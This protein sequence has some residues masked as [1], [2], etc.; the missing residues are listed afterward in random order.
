MVDSPPLGIRGYALLCTKIF[1]ARA[2][3]GEEKLGIPPRRSWG[4]KLLRRA[5][6]K[7]CGNR[8]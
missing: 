4:E 5:I 6:I 8:K 3:F 2:N 1:A 7:K